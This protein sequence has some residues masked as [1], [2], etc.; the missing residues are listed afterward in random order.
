MND[1]SILTAHRAE[2]WIIPTRSDG[3]QLWPSISA[4]LGSKI[5]AQLSFQSLIEFA[6]SSSGREGCLGTRMR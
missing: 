2:A 6:A 5:K 4:I 3:L 1:S